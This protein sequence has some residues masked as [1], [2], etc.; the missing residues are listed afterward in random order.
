MLSR[1]RQ[2]P[3][4]MPRRHW[5]HR[6]ITHTLPSPAVAFNPA[7]EPALSTARLATYRAAGRNDDHA[8]ALYRWNLDLAAAFTALSCDV[9]VTLRNTI[10]DHLTS[11]FGRDDWWAST[12]LVLDDITS[13]TLT[14]VVRRHRKQLAKGT[15]GPGKVIADLM[16]GTWVMLLGRGGTSALGRAIDYEANLW[17]PALRFGFA[18]GSLAPS[19][20]VR[21][22]T[23]DAV[24][25]RAS[26]LQRLR[27]RAAHHEPIFDGIRLAGTKDRIDLL[28]VWEQAVE[29]LGWM[30]PDLAAVHRA[31]PTLPHVFTARP[32]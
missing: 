16:L 32:S 26:N 30:N 5:R 1:E 6:G 7:F 20:R 18:T 4:R 21:R 31:T 11:Y 28:T 29:L 3:G 12:D 25:Q 9:E 24:H 14:E 19:G 27:N 23:R 10:H 13:E 22:P 17:R 8:W 15:I 2:Y